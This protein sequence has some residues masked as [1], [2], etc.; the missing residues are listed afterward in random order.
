MQI[1]QPLQM[2]YVH[3][4]CGICACMDNI[5]HACSALFLGAPASPNQ[6]L[7][8]TTLDVQHPRL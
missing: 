3:A 8:S 1:Q 4:E 7:Y 5:H 2:V 6:V